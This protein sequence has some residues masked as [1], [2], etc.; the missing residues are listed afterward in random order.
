VSVADEVID[1]VAMA[2]GL[3][4]S[5][6]FLYSDLWRDLRIGGDDM[7]ELF[8]DLQKK[9]NLNLDRLHLPTYSPNEDDVLTEQIADWVSNKLHLRRSGNYKSLTVADLIA[10]VERKSWSGQT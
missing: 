6:I 8:L 3:D 9:Y 5:V 4:P 7:L 1:S 10:V 2:A